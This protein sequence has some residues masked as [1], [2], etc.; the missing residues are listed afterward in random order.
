MKL[1]ISSDIHGSADAARSLLARIDEETPDRIVLLGDLLY[2]GPRNP[3]PSGYA[4]M[5]VAGMLNG[6]KDSIVAVRG[7]CDSEVDQM[8]LEFPCRSDFA[9]IETEGHLLY[10]TH[11][12]LAG[13]KSS[14]LP[15]LPKGA[16][17]VSGHTHVKTLDNRGGVLLVNPGSPSLPK[18][19]VP[20]YAVYEKGMFTLKTLEGGTL[21][22]LGW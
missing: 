10:L 17:F 18:D 13:M 14:D 15:M 4:P 7:N 3:L 19:A 1:L 21:R 5:D 12:H 22:Q 6:L 11:G 2:H 20:S 9:L 16:A 8:V